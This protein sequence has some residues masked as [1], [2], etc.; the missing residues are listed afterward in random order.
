MDNPFDLTI[1]GVGKTNVTIGKLKGNLVPTDESGK[2]EYTE[3]NQNECIDIDDPQEL[4]GK[5][6]DYKLKL[7]YIEIF[8]T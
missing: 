2:I 4:L 1:I 6:L 7:D 5:R 3:Q 8:D